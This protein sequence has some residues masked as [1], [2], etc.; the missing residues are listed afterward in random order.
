MNFQILKIMG[1]AIIA[2]RLS[3]FFLETSCVRQ[4]CFVY[5]TVKSLKLAQGKICGGTEKTQG[6]LNE[7]E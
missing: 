5:E 3:S 2:V 7:I 6:I 1:I 4:A